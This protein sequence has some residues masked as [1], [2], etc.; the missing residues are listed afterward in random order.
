MAKTVKQKEIN[1]LTVL[2]GRRVRRRINPR[3]FIMP[4]VLL[5]IVVVGVGIFG[6]IY[7]LT[8]QVDA[9]SNEIR[10]YLNS[11]DTARKIA[12]AENLESLAQYMNALA[13]QVAAPMESIATY[14][15][16]TSADYARIIGSA[17]ANIELSTMSFDRTTGVLTFTATSDYVLSIPTFISQLR[18]SGIFSAVSYSGYSSNVSASGQ[19]AQST[20][21]YDYG[22]E[23]Y[24]FSATYAFRVECVVKPPPPPPP[25]GA[26]EEVAEDA[27]AEEAEEGEHG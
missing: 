27:P 8:A 23:S 16:L 14:P 11:Q 25:P 3:S 18:H 12:E 2:A 24:Y 19:L 10:A 15:D 1:F 5:L 4:G 9:E 22:Y 20:N 17:G 13:Q 6:F 26:A 21:R 7:S